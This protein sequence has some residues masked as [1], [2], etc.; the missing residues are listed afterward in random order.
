MKLGFHKDTGAKVAVKIINKE[1]VTNKTST[2]RK[3]QREIA[4]MKLLQHKHI[5][6]LY[7]VYETSKYL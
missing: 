3:I 7:E 1:Y 2:L 5:L 4:V 6:S